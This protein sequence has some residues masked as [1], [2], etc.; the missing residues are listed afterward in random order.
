MARFRRGLYEAATYANANF[1][2]MVPL[3]AKYSGV[4]E[5]A[6]AAMSLSPVATNPSQ[7]DPKMIQPIIDAAVKYKALAAT[8]P[9]KDVIDPNALV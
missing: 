2:Q 6:I 7:L 5:K 4:D 1:Q 3:L 8:F 9:A